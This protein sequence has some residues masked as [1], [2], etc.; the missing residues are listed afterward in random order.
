M[1]RIISAL[2]VLLLVSFAAVSAEAYPVRLYTRETAS[3]APSRI[4]RI[5]LMLETDTS[6][7]ALGFTLSFP[8]EIAL[9]DVKLLQEGSVRYS[10]GNEVKVVC[11]AGTE[12][13]SGEVVELSLKPSSDA[14][15]DYNIPITDIG[16]VDVSFKE[17][18]TES[19]HI[20]VTVASGSEVSSASTRS[21]SKSGASSK[22]VRSSVSSSKSSKKSVSS[23]KH[24]KS[25]QSRKESSGIPEETYELPK[26]GRLESDSKGNTQARYVV[27][28]ALGALA[29][30]G[31][32]YLAFNAG[33]N[34]GGKRSDIS[35]EE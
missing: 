15:G 17:S 35:D 24:V 11:L 4:A 29:F 28:G 12:F 10:P 34:S 31:M 16:A 27:A 8:D 20:L 2:F 1:K 21:T 33:R 26:F 14:E 19:S 23:S 30:V 7:S 13:S 25:S 6:L 18:E 3:A 32:L 9:S 5:S 22:S